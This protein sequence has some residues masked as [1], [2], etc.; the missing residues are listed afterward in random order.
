MLN[1]NWDKIDEAVG[2][3]HLDIPD[4]SLTVKGKVQLSSSTSGTSES[5]AATEKAV[6]A[7][8]DSLSSHTGDAVRH[9][10]QAERDKWNNPAT[11]ADKITIVDVGNYYVSTQTEGALQEIGQALNGLNGSIVSGVNSIVKG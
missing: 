8:N 3:I 10:T 9:I 6:K 11:T 2:S 7:V 5:L 4:A 1:E